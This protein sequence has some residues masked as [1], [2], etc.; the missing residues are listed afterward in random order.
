MKINAEKMEWQKK[1]ESIMVPRI[2]FKVLRGKR[3]VC[4]ID[5]EGKFLTTEKLVNVTLKESSN[6]KLQTLMLILNSPLPSFYIQKMLFS[7]TT[8]TS[9]VMDDIYVGE[10]PIPFH[11]PKNQQSFITLCDYMLFLSET[12]ERRKTENELIG[13]I[14]KRVIDSLVYELYFKAKFEDDDLKTDLLRLVEP[15]LKDIGNFKTEE[16]K[17]MLINEVVEKIKADNRIKKEIEKIKAHE[18]VKVVEGEEE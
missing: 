2:F 15:Y 9:R 17:L 14:D 13:F 6:Y 3:L 12:E 16:E 4:F 7:D 1:I 8:E 10:M 11:A 5:D 18:W